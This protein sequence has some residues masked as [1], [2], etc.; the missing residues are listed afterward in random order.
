MDTLI[1]LPQNIAQKQTIEAFLQ[2]L[3]IAYLPAQ[4]TPAELEAWLL[5]G[6]RAVWENMK[7]GLD[8][9]ARYK[10]GEVPPEEV[11]TLDELLN[12]LEHENH[13]L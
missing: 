8:W 7:S 9:V 10:R 11:K 3:K 1:V 6:Q 5:P 2:A 12:E 13:P 4:P